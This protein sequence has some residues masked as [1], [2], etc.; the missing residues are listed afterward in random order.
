M[1]FIYK[2]SYATQCSARLVNCTGK[3]SIISHCLREF[4]IFC[5]ALL[6]IVSKLLAR[7]KLFLHALL[8]I[9]MSN[10]ASLTVYVPGILGSSWEKA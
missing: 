2:D 3:F 5:I 4:C 9:A 10:Y 6:K 8:K 1:I 7:L